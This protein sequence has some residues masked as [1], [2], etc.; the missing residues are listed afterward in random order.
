LTAALGKDPTKYNASIKKNA[1]DSHSIKGR[2]LRAFRI[3]AE[4]YQTRKP[5]QIL[6]DVIA[7]GPL[8]PLHISDF[9]AVYNRGMNEVIS[10]L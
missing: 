5:H 2:D 10:I 8:D 9:T 6:F 1:P 4:R 7:T 3:A